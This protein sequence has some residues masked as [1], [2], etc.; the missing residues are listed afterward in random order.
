MFGS[1][2]ISKPALCKITS[3]IAPEFFQI[4]GFLIELQRPFQV[5]NIEIVVSKSKHLYVLLSY[6]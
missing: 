5:G 2:V 1:T 6:M 3:F 4:Q